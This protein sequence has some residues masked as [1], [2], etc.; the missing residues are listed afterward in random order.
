VLTHA[1]G[2]FKTEL[3][4]PEKAHFLD[5]LAEYRKRKMPLSSAASVLKSWAIRFENT[6]L[7]SQVFFH[8]FPNEL[9][10]LDDSGKTAGS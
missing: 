1:L 9:L 10:A 3:S 6:Y 4:A 2:Y 7:L 8:S 5:L